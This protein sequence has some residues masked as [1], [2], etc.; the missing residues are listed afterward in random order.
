M[1]KRD[2]ALW[3]LIKEKIPGFPPID[4]PG[5]YIFCNAVKQ[6]DTKKNLVIKNYRIK[7]MNF[8]FVTFSQVLTDRHQ[9]PLNSQKNLSYQISSHIYITFM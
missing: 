5:F 7:I 2:W 1:N 6:T 4:G 3:A 8:L 9:N